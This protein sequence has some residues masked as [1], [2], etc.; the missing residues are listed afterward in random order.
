MPITE[1]QRENLEKARI[2]KQKKRE[3]EE[4]A[5]KKETSTSRSAKKSQANRDTIMSDSSEEEVVVTKR[6]N[7]PVPKKKKKK[8]VYISDSD[9]EEEVVYKK[10]ATK[11][12]FK[13]P[14]KLEVPQEYLPPQPPKRTFYDSGMFGNNE[15]FHSVQPDT[16]YT[17]AAD[18]NNVI[19]LTLNSTNQLASLYQSYF[20]FKIRA[21]DNAGGSVVNT[22]GLASCIQRI[23]VLVAGVQA[24]D[25]DNYGDIVMDE[26][27]TYASQNKKAMLNNLEGF[28]NPDALKTGQAWVHHQPLLSLFRVN[29]E[30]PLPVVPG[31]GIQIEIYLKP[32]RNFFVGGTGQP[33]GYSVEEFSW[34]MPMKTPSIKYMEDL[35]E[36]VA[37]G[38]SLWLP[39][40]QTK[41][42]ISYF[43]GA[44]ESEFVTVVGP[45]TSI[46]SISHRFVASD[47]Y[48]NPAKDKNRISKS[49]GLSEW[50]LQYG[51]TK[52]PNTRNFK[53]S[54]D[55]PVDKE[56]HLIQYLSAL[57]GD[58]A[59]EVNISDF[60]TL[61][62]ENFKLSY[63]WLQ[64]GE[65]FGSGLQL[66]DA[67]AQIRTHVIC[68]DAVPAT[69]RCESMLFRDAILEI[70][71]SL[72]QIHT[73]PMPRKRKVVSLPNTVIATKV[74]TAK[75][76]RPPKGKIPPQLLPFIL[77]RKKKTL[78]VANCCNPAAA[79][80][81]VPNPLSAAVVAGSNK[82][83]YQNTINIPGRGIFQK[84]L[85]SRLLY[86]GHTKNYESRI[87][88]VI[89][90]VNE[91]PF[92]PIVEISKNQKFAL[93]F[94]QGKEIY[95]K[96][97]AFADNLTTGVT[98]RG[99][100]GGGGGIGRDFYA[101]TGED[102]IP[103]KL[104]DAAIREGR[105]SSR[106]NGGAPRANPNNPIVSY[107]PDV[108]AANP[109][110]V[111]TQTQTSPR[112]VGS[113][114]PDSI[115]V[116]SNLAHQSTLGTMQWTATDNSTDR[117]AAPDVETVPE[118]LT[119][120]IPPRLR[121]R[122]PI[123]AAPHRPLHSIM[124]ISPTGLNAD[125]QHLVNNYPNAPYV[126]HATLFPDTNYSRHTIDQPNGWRA[127]METARD[128]DDDM[129]RLNVAFQ[130]MTMHSLQTGP[131]NEPV[132][133]RIPTS[134]LERDRDVEIPGAFP[135]R[136]PTP[137]ISPNLSATPQAT[138]PHLGIPF[139]QR[140]ASARNSLNG[141]RHPIP[142]P[143]S[144][145][146]SPT[147]APPLTMDAAPAQSPM[148]IV[149]QTSARS[150]ID[151]VSPFLRRSSRPSVAP[152]VL[153][154]DE[155]FNQIDTR[156]TSSQPPAGRRGR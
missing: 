83:L 112:P 49:M 133:P 90:E 120:N 95:E 68:S 32:S 105:A 88:S 98:P 97:K 84:D 81:A 92:R 153:S 74:R 7:T 115:P 111:G 27:Y 121:D 69:T 130:N 36:G 20:R 86:G 93:E 3:E 52:L 87:P 152:Q 61:D 117:A 56:T 142:A 31:S 51:S 44:N 38:H 47:D 25:I 26:A 132:R 53:Y 18:G 134:N 78:C 96:R 35:K 57:S 101:Q 131:S 10:K 148:E 21:K 34:N 91:I 124:G 82:P 8:V 54:N 123:Y 45:S 2:A 110:L 144:P 33:T 29:K 127:E 137:V 28:R 140:P 107:S 126:P 102:S 23:R 79:S 114:R 43:S 122:P 106:N 113:R 149:E 64:T 155:D 94:Y 156:A 85:P 37:K 125:I 73:N 65:R 55:D 99:P 75:S 116:L 143:A 77:K 118:R 15:S 24:Y 16:G 6:K 62:N 136:T 70:N 46:Q 104:R 14:P 135:R 59:D 9:T 30:F 11:K 103:P 150:P 66:L 19:R 60:S 58:F 89:P 5:K 39:F 40:V 154:Y 100:G 141:D 76:G 72:V 145:V 13:E 48:N 1:R 12:T 129:A 108:I 50:Y 147:M 109:N 17:F 151:S 71:P 138:E 42:Q 146:R 41:T 139:H 67:N 63:N 128:T 22:N 119:I 80:F 4:Q